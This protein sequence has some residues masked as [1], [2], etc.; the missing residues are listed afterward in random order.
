MS[1]SGR[2]GIVAVGRNEGARLQACLRSVLASGCPL[3]YVDSGSVD[4]SQRLAGSMGVSVLALDAAR[5]FSAA[6][7]RNEGFDALL[8]RRPG[9]SYVQFVD[10][11]C[12]VRPGW[13]DRGVAE[14]DARPD[15]VAVCG[16]VRERSPE[17]TIYNRLCALEWQ[18]PFGEIAACGGNFMVRAEAFQAVGGFRS[19]VI[20]AEDDELC[21][22]LR[23]RGGKILHIDAEMVWHDLAMTR[24]VQW[25]RRARRAGHA[26]AQGADLHGR[27]A[28]RHFVKQ[29]RRIW[30]WGL[31]L[32]LASLALAWPTSGLS[33]A[34]LAAYPL[35]VLRVTRTGQR[36]GWSREDAMLYAGFAV[37][38]KFPE[39]SGLV[40]YHWRRRRGRAM[41]VI[42]HKES[43]TPV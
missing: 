39:L 4:G 23:R 20:A 36:R 37:L 6:R 14:L 15:A 26:F 22:R 18:K 1:G 28:E 8:E 25:W 38:A 19:E 11:D 40:Q 2:L 32:P 7:A 12:E 34:V 5:A 24:F 27:G 17:T 21:L 29:C 43:G 16:N 33:L 31:V 41:A 9:L 30:F 3:V 10:G 35:Q 42:E 13:L